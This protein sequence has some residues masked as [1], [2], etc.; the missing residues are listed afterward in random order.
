[1]KIFKTIL[2]SILLLAT[3]FLIG[4]CTSNIKEKY[5]NDPNSLNYNN[6]T[7]AS[8]EVLDKINNASNVTV[9]EA[10][11]SFNK[12]YKIYVDGEHIATISGKYINVTGDVFTL[13]DLNGN[14]L[15]QE[16]QIKRWG[17][18][19]NRLA[20]FMDKDENL[21]G[22]IGENVIKDLF[23]VSKYKF[24]F[25][26]NN[27]NEYAHT[28]EKIITLLYEFNVYNNSNEKIYNVEKNF[29]L[30]TD[31]YDITKVKDSDVKMEK[32]VFLTCIVDAIIDANDE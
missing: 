5:M 26:D 7:V 13:K 30:V 19:L 29:N 16:K 1:M 25:Y 15:A 3:L 4:G 28:K 6:Q 8:S 32:V 11:I 10:I 23:S 12:Q 27:K 18:K 31:S 9:K 21:D 2:C 17:I 24:H 14:T 22:Y 20:K